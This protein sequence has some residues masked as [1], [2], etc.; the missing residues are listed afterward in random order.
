MFV[1]IA[2][3]VVTYQKYEKGD[4]QFHLIIRMNQFPAEW[5]TNLTICRCK[6]TSSEIMDTF[7]KI[8]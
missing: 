6:I 4:E 2:F 7:Y 5:I 3:L 8:E 1:F